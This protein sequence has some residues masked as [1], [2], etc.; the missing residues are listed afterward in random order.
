MPVLMPIR[1]VSYDPHF[2][3]LQTQVIKLSIVI[4]SSWRM[5]PECNHLLVADYACWRRYHD[6]IDYWQCAG[7]SAREQKIS[8]G[9]I[10]SSQRKRGRL[11]SASALFNLLHI[12]VYRHYPAWLRLFI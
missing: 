6:E 2:S 10:F 5:A 1:P 12:W 4:N 8:M 7:Q 9:R 3:S 11:T